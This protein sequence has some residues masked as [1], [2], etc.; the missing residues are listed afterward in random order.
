MRTLG[1][2]GWGWG[3]CPSTPPARLAEEI[4]YLSPSCPDSKAGDSAPYPQQPSLPPHWSPGPSA[5]WLGPFLSVSRAG[6]KRQPWRPLQKSRVS[7]PEVK[8]GGVTWA[9]H[10][11]DT[12]GRECDP[13]LSDWA[14]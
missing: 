7:T 11:A 8:V 5:P 1:E 4:Q 10:M 9:V 2:R 6:G 3:G 13:D 14:K 12:D